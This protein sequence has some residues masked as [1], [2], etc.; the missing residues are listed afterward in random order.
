MPRSDLATRLA[1]LGSF[2]IAHLSLRFVLSPYLP[3][4]SYSTMLDKVSFHTRLRKANT[5]TAKTTLT[6]SPPTPPLAKQYVQICLLFILAGVVEAVVASRFGAP[7]ASYTLSY[8]FSQNG[9]DGQLRGDMIAAVS[10][11]ARSAPRRNTLTSNPNSTRAQNQIGRGGSR[12][13]PCLLRVPAPARRVPL[14]RAARPLGDR[15][16]VLFAV[17]SGPPGDRRVRDERKANARA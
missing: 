13:L 1:V 5:G 6:P 2:F 17:F 10:L 7:D 14:G 4:I 15:K 3:R 16:C 8:T 12:P 9:T 11:R